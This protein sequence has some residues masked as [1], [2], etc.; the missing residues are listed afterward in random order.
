MLKTI[1]SLT[2]ANNVSG[3]GTIAV[4]NANAV[5]IT[6]G[7]VYN[8]T[9]LTTSVDATIHGITVG[10]GNSSV[11][12]NTVVGYQAGYSNTTGAS[13][14]FFGYQSGFGVTTG[15]YNVIVGAYQG[16]AAPI[17]A[18]GSNYVVLS[19]G[20]ANVRGVFDSTGNF[21]V[22]GTSA[23]TAA[24]NRGTITINGSVGSLLSLTVGGA[25]KSYIYCD[26]TN[27][28]INNQANGY[29]TLE[30]NAIERM[31]ISAAG[32]VSIG[33]ITDPGATNLNVTGTIVSAKT[34]NTGGYIVATLPTGVTGARA[35]VT[36]A[37]APTFGATV[38]TGGAVTVPVFYNGSAWIVG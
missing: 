8:L 20:S 29:M 32:G 5:A 7:T 28:D 9:G 27:L 4:Q 35:Y 34:L 26:G 3:L 23:P 2:N 24:A 17:S 25:N 19:D 15:S 6:G 18:T 14:Q 33:N 37:L 36:N 1:S 16:S 22:G 13:N 38:V 11:T 21:I 12:T 10:L 30:T 31:R